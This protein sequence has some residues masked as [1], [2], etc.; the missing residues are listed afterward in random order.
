MAIDVPYCSEC[1]KNMTPESR[2]IFD[3]EN[4]SDKR[5]VYEVFWV[6]DGVKHTDLREYR[7]SPKNIGK[8]DIQLFGRPL[9]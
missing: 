5:V 9:G 6:C 2:G 1:E 8:Y 7:I 4:E 3:C